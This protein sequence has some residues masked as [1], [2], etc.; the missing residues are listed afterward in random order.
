MNQTQT[1]KKA[2]ISDKDTRRIEKQIKSTTFLLVKDYF[3]DQ[4]NE[5]DKKEKTKINQKINKEITKKILQEYK[6]THIKKIPYMNFVDVMM[7]ISDITIDDIRI[8]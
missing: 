1:I 4:I 5:V 2:K 3:G 6:I 8:S 7:F